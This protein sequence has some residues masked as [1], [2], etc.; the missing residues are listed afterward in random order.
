MTRV[1]IASVAGALLFGTLSVP[2]A[3]ELPPGGPVSCRAQVC[4]R[5]PN[6]LPGNQRINHGL[7]I[8]LAPVN[9]VPVKSGA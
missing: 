3:A 8:L 2:A 4:F 1:Q 7:R 6:G 5:H 9:R